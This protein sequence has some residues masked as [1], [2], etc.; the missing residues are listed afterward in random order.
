MTRFYDDSSILSIEMLDNST[1]AA[2]E[3]DFFEV[4]NLNY[5]ADLDA[6]KV[7]DVEYL[8]DYAKD[9]ANG[10]NPDFDEA[11]DCTVSADIEAL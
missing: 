5:N 8:A 3:A 10:T 1:G 9:Y 6:Y 11:G 4:G 2:F 7:D